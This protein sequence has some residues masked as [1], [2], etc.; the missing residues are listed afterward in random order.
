MLEIQENL[1]QLMIDLFVKG[2]L[3]MLVIRALQLHVVLVG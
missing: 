1:H 2:R 3:R